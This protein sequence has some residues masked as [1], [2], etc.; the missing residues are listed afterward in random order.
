M[1]SLSSLTTRRT[2]SCRVSA[3]LTKITQQIHSLRASGVRSSQSV[4]ALLSDVSAWRRSEGKV[5]TVPLEIFTL[6]ILFTFLPS[7]AR[8]TNRARR[9]AT[10]LM[11]TV[12]GFPA[13]V[14]FHGRSI[15]NNFILMLL[16]RV[17]VQPGGDELGDAGGGFFGLGF[18]HGMS[19]ALLLFRMLALEEPI[20]F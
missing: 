17:L 3:F 12:T 2:W 4:R 1:P 11:T 15:A 13:V 14:G 20:N 16:L 9:G 6:A 8:I 18:D 19:I 5:C 10:I 7:A